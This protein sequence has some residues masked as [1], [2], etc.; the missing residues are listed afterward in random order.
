MTKDG[1]TMITTTLQSATKSGLAAVAAMTMMT[2]MSAGA[3]LADDEIPEGVTLR[4]FAYAGSGCP[5]GT[6]NGDF[7]V[8]GDQFLISWDSMVAEVGP[9]VPFIN[10]RKNCQVNIDLDHP[11]GWQYTVESTTYAGHTSLDEGVTAVAGSAY[12][13]QGSSE[14]VRFNSLF[15]GPDD[16]AFFIT[17]SVA[18][19]DQVWSTCDATRSLNINYQIRVVDGTDGGEASGQIVFGGEFDGAPAFTL[20]KLKWRRC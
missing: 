9:G 15:E 6:V 2:A 14:T 10:K 16:R 1:G 11:H 18:D 8:A 13:F 3:A 19:G 4:G 12:Y 20:L 5:A 7:P 17:D